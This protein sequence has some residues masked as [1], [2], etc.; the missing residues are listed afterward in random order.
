M[1]YYIPPKFQGDEKSRKN[2]LLHNLGFGH[3][4]FL[5]PFVFFDAF[6]ESKVFLENKMTIKI[7]KI[8]VGLQ[9]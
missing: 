5:W 8:K 2:E 1:I 3:T 6:L 7:S 4:N 9:F